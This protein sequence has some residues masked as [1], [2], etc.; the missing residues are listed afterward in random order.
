MLSG[1]TGEMG[2]VEFLLSKFILLSKVSIFF[3]TEEDGKMWCGGGSCIAL[4]FCSC[5]G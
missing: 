4:V 2:E 1:V 3:L 5:H